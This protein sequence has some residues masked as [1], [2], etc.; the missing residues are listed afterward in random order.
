M[1]RN[2]IIIICALALAFTSFAAKKAVVYVIDQTLCDQKGDCVKVC[3][4]N[5]IKVTVVNGKKVHEI[6]PAKCTQCGKCIDIC[7][8]DDAIKIVDK[9]KYDAMASTDKTKKSK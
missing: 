5:A 4:Y 3:K 2:A 9:K 6:D 1:K 7:P 8:V